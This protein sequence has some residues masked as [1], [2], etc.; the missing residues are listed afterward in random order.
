MPSHGARL[1]RVGRAGE[2]GDDEDGFAAI[3]EHPSIGIHAGPL[4]GALGVLAGVIRA[5]DTGEGCRLEIAQSDAAAAMD[6]LRSETWKAY[7]RPE[8]EVTGNESDGFKRRAPG[9]AGMRDG[10]RYQFYETSDGHIL[11]QA[12]ASAS[13]GRTSAAASAATTCSRSAR[14]RSTP[15]TRSATSSCARSSRTSSCRRTSAEWV[16]LGGRGEHADRQR[17]HA[18]DA[19]RRPAVPGPLPVDPGR[20]ARRRAAPHAAQVPRRRAARA[21]QGA[22][23]RPAH[24]RGAAATSSATTTPGSRSLRESGALG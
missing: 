21:D 11:F 24:R 5:R 15:T 4:F 8:S 20:A 6:W 12:S 23:R 9:T 13:S 1:R 17:E 14:A 2:A 16:E 19:G 22:D 7:E 10:V 18:E 3:P